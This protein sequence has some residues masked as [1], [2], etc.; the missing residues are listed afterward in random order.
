MRPGEDRVTRTLFSGNLHMPKLTKPSDLPHKATGQARCRTN[1][2]DQY[3][4]PYGSTES[5]EKYEALIA[6]WFARS[7]DTSRHNLT[8][9]DLARLFLEF[10]ENY[11]RRENGEPTGEARNIRDALRPLIRLYG[12][13]RVREFGPLKLKAVRDEMIRARHCR[14][15]INCEIHRV[16]RVFKWGVENEYVPAPIHQALVAVAGLKSGR[17]DAVESEPVQP[18]PEATVNATL[19]HLSAVVAD[20]VRL[21]L[22]AGCR[23]GEVC[24]LRPCDVTIQPDGVWVYRPEHHKTEHHGRER[25]NL[26][27]PGRSSRAASLPRP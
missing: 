16:R 15:H 22:L 11:Y 24:V 26:H 23:P 4:G 8:I 19:P 7:G 6:E 9:D 18:V 12:K 20:M 3:L 27:R 21:Q 17:S 5:R 10:A 2:R 14:S 25:R 13:S 1:G